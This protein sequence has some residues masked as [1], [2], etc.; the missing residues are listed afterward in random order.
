M[1]EWVVLGA[2]I[3]GGA[4][5]TVGNIKA[6]REA[7]KQAYR[8]ADELGRQNALRQRL[9]TEKLRAIDLE[10]QRAV[11]QVKQGAAGK[12]LKQGGSVKLLSQLVAEDFDRRGMYLGL[13]LGEEARQT[14]EEIANLRRQGRRFASGQKL[15]AAKSMLS[16]GADVGEFGYGRG[17]FTK[18]GGG[19]PLG[20][21]PESMSSMYS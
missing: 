8:Q 21:V 5:E 18:K 17:W 14:A 19:A 10:G 11:G 7:K 12:G 1:A 20:S 3:G 9:G 13:G 4:M 16:T 6:G 2:M 15:M